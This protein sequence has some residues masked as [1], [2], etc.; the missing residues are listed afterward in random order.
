MYRVSG[1]A[2]LGSQRQR[3]EMRGSS[4][5]QDTRGVG[6][7]S[8]VSTHASAESSRDRSDLYRPRKNVRGPATRIM[9]RMQSI[10]NGECMG[11]R[12]PNSM[13]MVHKVALFMVTVSWGCDETHSR[14][15]TH[16]AMAD[17]HGKGIQ[18]RLWVRRVSAAMGPLLVQQL[19]GR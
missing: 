14:T 9:V 5:W 4:V 17:S 3:K 18:L 6:P 13:T 7:V 2:S 16:E 11:Q 12:R 10:S 1:I 19:S 15:V 8:L